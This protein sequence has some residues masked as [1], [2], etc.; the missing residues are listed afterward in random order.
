MAARRNPRTSAAPAPP[1]ADDRYPSTGLRILP[2]QLPEI[3]VDRPTTADGERLANVIS[4]R[5]M[6]ALTTAR[7][8]DGI[9]VTERIRALIAIWRDVPEVGDLV[10]RIARPTARSQASL[11]QRD[12]SS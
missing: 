12:E 7:E 9:T 6:R 10:D 4:P 8:L 11:P 2:K 3:T 5:D 1:P